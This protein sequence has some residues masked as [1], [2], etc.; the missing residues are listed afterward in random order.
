MDLSKKITADMKL[1]VVLHRR[2]R[3]CSRAD[4]Q[5]EYMV[6]CVQS[7]LSVLDHVRSG[8]PVHDT[9]LHIEGNAIENARAPVPGTSQTHA[10]QDMAPV[11]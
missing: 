9:Q 10:L 7:V 6:Q 11:Y 2:P 3:L 1:R 4:R 5:H 8:L